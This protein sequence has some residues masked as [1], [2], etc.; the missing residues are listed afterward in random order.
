MTVNWGDYRVFDPGVDRPL[1][2]VSRR[3]AKRHYEKLMAEKEERKQALV[4]LLA[5]EGVE[6]DGSERSVQQLNDWFRASVEADPEDDAP[7]PRLAPRWFGVINDIAVYLGDLLCER[8]P[9]LHWELYVWGKRNTA[10]QRPVIMGFDA[11]NSK[12]NLDLDAA[13]AVDGHR[14]VAGLSVEEDE[15]VAI[16]H[17]AEEDGQSDPPLD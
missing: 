6:L 11:P 3:Q 15:F 12:F 16:L 10:Y 1:H 14:V 5:R 9:R 7:K 2:E 4:E 8:N 13:I 17:E